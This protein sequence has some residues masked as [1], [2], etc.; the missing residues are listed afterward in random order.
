MDAIVF[1]GNTKSAAAVVMNQLKEPLFHFLLA[2]AALFGAY[3]WM[4]RATEKPAADKAAQ[5]RISTGDVQWLT[6]NWTTQWQRPPMPEELRGLI[7]DYVNEQLLAREARALGLEDNDVIIRRRLAQKLTFLIDDTM[8]RAEP[9]EDELRQFYAANAQQFRTGTRISLTHVYFSPQRRADA[10]SDAMRTL[11]LLL[12]ADGIRSTAELGDRLLIAPE[13]RDETEQ[14]LASAFGPAFAR[15]V[16]EIKT[17]AW[18]GPFESGYGLHLVRVLTRQ[19]ANL[20]PL[21]QVRP[22]VAEEWKREQDQLAKERYIAELRRK[23]D[24]VV[25][26]DAKALVAPALTNKTADK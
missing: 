21:A 6:E 8:R 20:P 18:S 19:D 24:I 9:T 14:S 12:A 1:P 3:T 10:R 17:D 5:I 26:D 22:R 15:A 23:Y 4:N 25:D 13:L 11:K 16:F 2:G 7:T